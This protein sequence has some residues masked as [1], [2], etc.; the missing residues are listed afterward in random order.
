M[1]NTIEYL[2]DPMLRAIY[3]PGIVAGAATV[4]ACAMLSPLV[5]VKRLGFIGQGVSHSAFGGVGVA[6]MLA[7]M[8]LIAPAGPAEFAIVLV[9]CIAAA[10]GMA[11]IGS[12]RETPEDTAIGLFLVGSMAAGALL[13]HSA[14]AVA[15]S[16][17]RVPDARSW[18][19]I[20]FGS[21]TGV[22]PFERNLA[23]ATLAVVALTC[24][25][26]RR[27]LAFWAFDDDG[28]RA[29]GVPTTFCR[30]ALMTL[31]ALAI[32]TA[33]KTVGVVLA[34]AL[35]VLPGAIALRLADRFAR[36]HAIAGGAGVLGLVGGLML[37]FELGW[38]PGPC[39]V[40]VL[41]ALFAAVA[42]WSRLRAGVPTVAA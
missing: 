18:E 3:L 10:W 7:A 24:W 6:A 25:A 29:F 16:A 13:V 30:L 22:G 21:M 27:P 31:L 38:Q 41:V 26:L 39:V 42:A 11:I 8:G 17:G 5:V 14:R 23:L 34:S 33:M 9:F 28:A 1:M 2:R 35:I 19:S 32:V 40:A 37:A 15:R 36:V 20:L 4:L 12:R